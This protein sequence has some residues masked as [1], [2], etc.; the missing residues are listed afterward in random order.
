MMGAWVVVVIVV[1]V[2][3]PRVVLGSPGYS[4]AN[5]TLGLSTTT[6]TTTATAT[7]QTPSPP[8]RERGVPGCVPYRARWIRRFKLPRSNRKSTAFPPAPGL[9]R[10]WRVA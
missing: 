6:T 8:P 3:S 9:A 5:T 10:A 4:G 7:R 1:G 2:H